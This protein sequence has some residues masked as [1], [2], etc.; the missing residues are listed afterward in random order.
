M[1]L[2]RDHIHQA[3]SS[4]ESCRIGVLVLQGSFAE[5]IESLRLL[6][7]D[8][9]RVNQPA[10]LETLHG[11][12]IPGGESTTL[13]HLMNQSGMIQAIVAAARCG[14][15][16]YGSC[17]G[18]ILL[19]RPFS[20]VSS[21]TLNLLDI[22]VSRNWY[23]GQINSFELDLDVA[24]LD[25]GPFRAIF[26]RA[27]AILD[28][29]TNVEVLARLPDGTP[30]AVRHARYL[31]TA[32]HPELTDDLRIHRLFID[33][34]CSPGSHIPEEPT[35]I[36]ILH[37]QAYHPSSGIENKATSGHRSGASD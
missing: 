14:M 33:M 25:D 5:H 15:A 4:T 23:G 26:I 30:V 11:L 3:A 20:H 18:L 22:E 10:H 17:A 19:G 35:T 1:Q 2:Q 12:I 24:D 28:V 37:R 36:G 9:I 29:G 34:A 16:I 7:V 27:P 31:A 32:F 13:I 8:A 6:G 21:N